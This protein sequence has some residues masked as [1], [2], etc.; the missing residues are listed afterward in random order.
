[1]PSVSIQ[2]LL[3]SASILAGFVDAVAGGGGLITIPALL[4]GLP[5]QPVTT[6]LGTNKVV[7][8]TGTTFAAAQFL[9][10]RALE[11][12]ELLVPVLLAMVGSAGGVGAAYLLQGR[13]ESWI[14]PAMV[15]LMVLVGAVIVLKPRMGRVH[16]PRFDLP[17]QRFLAA[18][19]AMV[20]GFYDGIFG[21]GTGVLLIFLFVSILGFDFLRASALAK[22]VNWASN[23]AALV[24]FVSKGSWLPMLALVMALGNGL[25]GY[26]GARMALGKGSAWVRVLFLTVVAAMILRLGCQA[27]H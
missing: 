23:F 13:F 17:H 7:A 4:L 1:M 19:I 18:L 9:R 26:L 15:I 12:R 10:S 16:A 6:I 25:G 24:L 8:F 11:A 14:K 22:C 21:P 3:V 27:L 2:L 20:L 5:G